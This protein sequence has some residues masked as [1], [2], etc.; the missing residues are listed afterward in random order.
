[1]LYS[2]E[3]WMAEALKRAKRARE[4]NEVPV[5]AILVRN[6][7]IV[8]E[9]WNQSI[10]RHNPTAHAE[11]IAL[12]Q[13]GEYCQNYRLLGTTLY[14][15]LEP[16]MMCAGAM[17]HSRIDSLVYGAQDNKTGAAG[18]FIDLLT[19]PGINHKISIKGGVLVKECGDILHDFFQMRRQE[20][21]K[22]KNIKED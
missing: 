15:T 12:K 19:L 21:K 20:I 3:Y 2:D 4:E 5:G 17:I 16:C 11:I 13:A 10:T 7:H 1:M 6:N 14:V 18:S 22:D 9:G 8:G